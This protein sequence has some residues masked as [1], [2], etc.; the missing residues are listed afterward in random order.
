MQTNI[1]SRTLGSRLSWT[2]R[3]GVLQ[4]IVVAVL[5]GSGNVGVLLHGDS[6]NGALRAH[7]DDARQDDK[8]LE[9]GSSRL[10]IT[11]CASCHGSLAFLDPDN[12]ADRWQSAWQIW[13]SR[14]PHS[15]AY[16]TLRNDQSKQIVAALAGHANGDR[17]ESQKPV[18]DEEYQS[19]INDR[20]ISCHSTIPAPL[21]RGV[22]RQSDG[23][24][25]DNELFMSQGVSCHSCHSADALDDQT[26]NSWVERHVKQ[27]WS[28]G[29]DDG[30]SSG[31]INLESPDIRAQTCS[32]CHVGSENRDV[33]HDLIAAGHPRLVFEYSSLLSR[34]PKH[35][36]ETAN[37]SFHVESWSVGQ[38][39]LAK[40]SVALLAHRAQASLNG[41]QPWP[42]FAEYNCHNC[43]H[44]LES[45]WY[46][47]NESN[48]V[49]KPVWGEWA[50]PA[51]I[52]L[53]PWLDQISKLRLE[54]QKA[55]VD[56]SSVARLSSLTPTVHRGAHA[57]EQISA[58]LKRQPKLSSDELFA[59]Y[60]AV[61]SCLRDENGNSPEKTVLLQRMEELWKILEI[62][63]D[64]ADK[65]RVIK[66]RELQL[67]IEEIRKLVLSILEQQ[68][69]NGKP[70]P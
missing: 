40:A 43:H 52:D 68:H 57:I 66:T 11:G 62:P 14:D 34:L 12:P 19:I 20:C 59:W 7:R 32:S 67:L 25:T 21:S 37:R 44:D 33:N 51:E 63:F 16:L 13:A 60:L 29:E 54:M 41:D 50:F 15:Q 6:P 69:D 49:G 58:Y 1:G 61:H 53:K 2:I 38:I 39:E 36:N 4:A 65:N 9:P 46:I 8:T 27:A 35:W 47:P 28:S 17:A 70:Q 24:R 42:E 23:D 64:H 22:I 31:L 26:G 48:L 56:A 10:S 55:Y 30:S 45:N 3:W 18:D 5:A